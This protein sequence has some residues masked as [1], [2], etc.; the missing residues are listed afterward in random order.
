MMVSL[1]GYQEGGNRGRK[2]VVMVLSRNKGG[3]SVWDNEYTH[4][5]THAHTV[6]GGE[7]GVTLLTYSSG[8]LGMDFPLNHKAGMSEMN[9]S[10]QRKKT[11]MN[12]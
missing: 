7:W 6:R 2:M 11:V 12:G 1:L 5:D 10:G 4:T 8:D 9:E 3:A